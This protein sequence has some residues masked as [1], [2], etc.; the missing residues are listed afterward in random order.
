[1]FTIIVKFIFIHICVC[2]YVSVY[3]VSGEVCEGQRNFHDLPR[4]GVTGT[5][6]LRDMDAGNLIQV[7]EEQHALL[8]AESSQKS[9][10]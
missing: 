6:E 7:L 9:L 4:A 2:V 1:M 8:T 10:Q 5:C 3:H